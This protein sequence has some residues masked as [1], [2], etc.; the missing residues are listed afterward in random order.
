M[1][2][3]RHTFPMTLPKSLAT[4]SGRVRAKPP[5]LVLAVFSGPLCILLSFECLY[6]LVISHLSRV[7]HNGW[8]FCLW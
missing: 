2:S 6:Q 7:L 5:S 4:W 1:H 8:K 3:T